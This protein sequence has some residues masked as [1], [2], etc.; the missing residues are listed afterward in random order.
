MVGIQI[1]NNTFYNNGRG[2]WGGGI[3]VD[4]PYA[5]NVVIRNNILSQNL[6]FQLEVEPDVSI[7]SLV[8]DHNLIH[9]FRI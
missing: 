9:G 3:A 6:L 2:S 4:N 8:V 5:R 7:Q 1:L